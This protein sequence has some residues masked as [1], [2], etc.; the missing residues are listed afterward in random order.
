MVQ[1]RLQGNRQPPCHLCA[2][3]HACMQVTI[4]R[5]PNSC[6]PKRCHWHTPVFVRWR[7]AVLAGWLGEHLGWSAD[8]VATSACQSV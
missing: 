5:L 8:V 1:H 7:A 3:T 4:E 6:S 2:R